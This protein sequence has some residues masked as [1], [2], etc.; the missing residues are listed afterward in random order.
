M[1]ALRAL[2]RPANGDKYRCA[3]REYCEGVVAM[4]GGRCG[5]T[6]SRK[7]GEKLAR[8]SGG[9]ALVVLCPAT[10]KEFSIG[11]RRIDWLRSHGY[12]K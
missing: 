10:G 11:R 1:D 9:S 2:D 8:I 7:E 6:M 12:A 4:I 3:A 5:V